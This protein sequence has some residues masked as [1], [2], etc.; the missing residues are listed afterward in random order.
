MHVV[1]FNSNVRGGWHAKRLSRCDSRFYFLFYFIYF[2]FFRFLWI[3]VSLFLFF[4]HNLFNWRNGVRRI[5]WQGTSPSLWFFY[6]I[7][8]CEI[9]EKK[10]AALY[11]RNTHPVYNK[12]PSHNASWRRRRR[13]FCCRCCGVNIR[14]LSRSCYS[15]RKSD[16]TIWQLFISRLFFFFFSFINSSTSWI[17]KK[18]RIRKVCYYIQLRERMF[19]PSKKRARDLFCFHFSLDYLYDSATAV[20]DALLI[21]WIKSPIHI[22]FRKQRKKKKK[23]AFTRQNI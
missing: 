8:T 4:W 15:Q 16:L 14:I 18:E 9:V 3:F 19:Q 5:I 6:E 23:W 12:H 20:N 2:F 7:Y 1:L 11:I 13:V 22:Q 21:F 17:R 10:K